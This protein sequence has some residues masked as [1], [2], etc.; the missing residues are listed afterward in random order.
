MYFQK[1]LK[2]LSKY[3]FLDKIHVKKNQLLNG[4]HLKHVNCSTTRRNLSL[5]PDC[6]ALIPGS[7]TYP[8]RGVCVCACVY[9]RAH[10][11]REII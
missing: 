11:L 6:L 8:A 10:L 1:L 3:T 2:F 4:V 7:N 5:E 9:A